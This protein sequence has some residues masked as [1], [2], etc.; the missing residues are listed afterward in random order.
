MV[1][2]FWKT[3][4]TF[5]KRETY[6]SATTRNDLLK[7][8]YQ[9]ITN[10]LLKEVKA[11]KI[12]TLILMKLQTYQIKSISFFLR[13]VDNSND[14]REEFLKFIHCDEGVTGRDLF[15][16]VANTLS[17]FG[18]DLMNYRVREYD[19]AGSIAG[20]VNG[21]SRMRVVLESNKLALYTHFHSHRLNLAVSSLTRII[22]FRNV[23]DD[24]K[25]ISYFFNLSPKNLLKGKN[26]WK[27]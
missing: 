7:Y 9:V 8:C 26:I 4:K 1:T 19:R 25:A 5:I 3:I 13:F 24:I 16:A 22:S 10:C 27:K 18:L 11:S 15:E 20:K 23:M 14:I 2:K 21:L 17:E 6:F 12:F